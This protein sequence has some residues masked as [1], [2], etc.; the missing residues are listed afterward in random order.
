MKSPTT[1]SY[2]FIRCAVLHMDVLFVFLFDII[3]MSTIEAWR[4]R[5]K[6]Y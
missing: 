3:C 2:N 4:L 5:Y 6:Y 1:K